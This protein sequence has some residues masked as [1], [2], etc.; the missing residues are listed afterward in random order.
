M[1]LIND[2]I[3]RLKGAVLVFFICV[4]SFSVSAQTHYFDP[5]APG[6]GV[7]VTQDSGQGS[8][9]IWYLYDRKGYPTWLISTKNCTDY[10]CNINLAQPVGTWMGGEFDLVEVGSVTVDFIDG[11]LFWEYNLADWPDA[12]DCGRLVWLYQ[13]KCVGTFN[14]EAVD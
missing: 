2:I 14:M 13:T 5:E 4:Q 11:D 7:S 9:F 8:A 3:K 6:H 10:P 12:G 1:T